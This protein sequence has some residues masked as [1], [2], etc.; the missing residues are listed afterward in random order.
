MITFLYPD[1]EIL[2]SA[3]QWNEDWKISLFAND[4]MPILD[5]VHISREAEQH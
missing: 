5:L 2:R 4:G 3:V 1:L